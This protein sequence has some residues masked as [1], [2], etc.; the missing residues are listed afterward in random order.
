MCW[1]CWTAFTGFRTVFQIP[2][3]KCIL[4]YFSLNYIVN[5][6]SVLNC[7][8]IGFGVHINVVEVVIEMMLP[9]RV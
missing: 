6:C 7:P 2:C 1:I 4:F 3:T 5:L 9:R 8:P